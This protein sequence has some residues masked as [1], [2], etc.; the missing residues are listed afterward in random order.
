MLLMT[1]N[2]HKLEE[3]QRLM[4]QWEWLSF[5]EWSELNQKGP[6]PDIDETG[7]SFSE[8]AIIKAKRVT[9]F[10][11]SSLHHIC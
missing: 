8:N 10:R 6:Y 4:P 2:H 3:F 7:D 11:S 5:K 1:G 9:N